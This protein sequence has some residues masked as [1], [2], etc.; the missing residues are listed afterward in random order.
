MKMNY[1]NV[2]NLV[3]SC[4]SWLHTTFPWWKKTALSTMGNSSSKRETRHCAFRN[5][6][7]SRPR[8]CTGV[9]H[10]F[11]DSLLLT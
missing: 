5:D 3:S 7:V 6:G 10:Q 2:L 11:V 9:V 4:C 8:N 1:S